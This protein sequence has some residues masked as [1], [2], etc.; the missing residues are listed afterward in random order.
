[1]EKFLYNYTKTKI[2][3][4]TVLVF[5][6][7]YYLGMSSLGFQSVFHCLQSNPQVH[8]ERAFFNSS[9][10]KIKTIE[11]GR[12]LNQFDIIF[13]SISFE[14]DLINII[15]IL[16]R[17]GIEIRNK[18]RSFPFIVI[19]GIATTIIPYYLKGI[20]DIVVSGDA[21][22]T[23]PP[24]IDEF[25]KN[26]E[27]SKESIL[28]GIS[29]KEGIYPYSSINSD[30]LCY[31]KS[32]PEN[33]EP[34]HSVILTKNTEFSN[35]GLIEISSSCQYRCS[36]CLVS[37][38]YGDYHPL[39]MGKIIQTAE[40]YIGFTKK[41]GLIAATLSNHP[42]FKNIIIELNKIGFQISFS[43]FRIEG[44]DDELLHLIIE[45]EN[46]TLVIAPE[47]ASEKLKKNLNKVIPNEI[48]LSTVKRACQFGIKRL[49]LYFIIGIPGEEEDDLDADIRLIGD[50]REITQ[51]TAAD[52][53]YIPEIIVDINPLV[54]KPFT[55]FE[56]Q[57]MENIK[58]LR[59]KII[60]LKNKLRKM[61]RTFVYGE[62]PRSSLLQYQISNHL[63]S[64]EEILKI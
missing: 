12:E 9:T 64:L 38:V 60:Y 58:T 32:S 54:P 20:A 52:W 30:K 21:G 55:L 63:L 49:K 2:R 39:P 41:L 61:G 40:K 44:L 36:F 15:E 5:P 35:R 3:I 47:T 56:G 25:L 57:P 51:E 16:R 8:C 6:N 48:V 33:E 27:Y 43:A 31:Q 46:K 13:F 11:S 7:S 14:N 53:G 50:I 1:M 26:P 24:L 22:L 23:I 34:V 28:A 17:S 29:G 59:K 10:S 19:G 42:D 18:S 4:N 45:N 37:S 62:S